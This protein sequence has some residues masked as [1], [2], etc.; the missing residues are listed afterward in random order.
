MDT[1]KGLKDK[2]NG[3]KERYNGGDGI[4]LSGLAYRAILYQIAE[5]VLDKVI[6]DEDGNM[7][8][9]DAPVTEP[10]ETSETSEIPETSETPETTTIASSVVPAESS[11]EEDTTTEP[12]E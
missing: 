10:T 4:H 8:Y 5:R 7:I 6:Y 3:L 12:Q 2:N 1:A 11:E 9:L